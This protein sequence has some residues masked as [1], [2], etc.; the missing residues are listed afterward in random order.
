MKRVFAVTLAILFAVGCGPIPLLLAGGGA[1]SG[2]GHGGGSGGGASAGGAA[3]LAFEVAPGNAAV[4]AV[5]A[6]AV[7]VTVSDGSSRSVTLAL[8][9]SPG[10]AALGGTTTQKTAGGAAIFADLTVDR[11]GSGYTL[12]ASSTG[13]APATSAAFSI[14][15]PPPSASLST[16][17]ANPAGH[18]PSDGLTKSTITIT[19]RDAS[20]SPIAGEVLSLASTGS[21]NTITQ[22]ASTD[23][24]GVAVGAIASSVG[25]TKTI[26]VTVNPGAGQVVLSQQPQVEFEQAQLVFTTQPS[27]AG[28]GRAIAPAVQVA[29]ECICG[30]VASSYAGNVTLRIGANPGGGTLSGTAVASASGGDATFANLS[31]DV[32]APGYTLVASA[33]NIPSATST[34]FAVTEA[35]TQ[36]AP[37]GT[38]PAARSDSSA[39]LDAAHDR[40]IVFG[41]SSGNVSAPTTMADLWLLT[42]ADGAG[43]TPAWIAPTTAGVAPSARAMHSAVYDAASNRL[44]VFGGT[45][46][47][48]VCASDLADVWILTNAN[49]LGGTPTWSLASPG[50]TPPP[51]RS[52][53]SAVYDPGSN[54][55]VVFGGTTQCGLPDARVFV[56]SNANGTESAPPLWTEIL[57]AGMPPPGRY[58]HSAVFDA[59]GRMIVFGGLGSGATPLQDVWVLA[60]ASGIGASAWTELLSTGPALGGSHRAVYNPAANAMIAYGGGRASP[61]SGAVW[62]L[63]NANGAGSGAPGW[64]QLAPGGG[65]PPTRGAYGVGY[66]PATHTMTVFGGLGCAGSCSELGDAWVFSGR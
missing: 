24:S 55:M 39:A 49:G 2:G 31:I 1:A 46:T 22:P 16:A 48:G 64:T 17:V 32:A 23:S 35:W 38:S 56:L 59:G 10:G 40:L 33:T 65:P 8:G 11:A 50:G 7:K 47:V 52:L 9:A 44:V 6:P 41:G 18:V 4:G 27:G 25:E 63:S 14:G 3:V 60:A 58:A 20:G 61:T 5:I 13:L 19:V 57:P 30:L 36:L 15:A 43:G 21:G 54:R 26:T 66:G 12:V 29:V 45:P 34:A 37:T 51:G 53:H 62:L 42:H 28:A